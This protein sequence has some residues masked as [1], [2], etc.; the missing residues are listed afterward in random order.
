VIHVDRRRADSAQTLTRP[1]S[2]ATATMLGGPASSSTSL[3]ARSL[4][5]LLALPTA[6]LLMASLVSCGGPRVVPD[7]P[8]GVDLA[9]QW[10]LNRQASEDPRALI[11]KL[12]EKVAKQFRRGLDDD[13]YRD[14]PDSEPGTSTGSGPA[15]RGSS[16]APGGGADARGARSSDQGGP[17]DGG[18]RSRTNPNS[19]LRV[20][21]D[22]ALGSRLIGDGLTIEQSPDRFAITRGDW[23]RS[24]TPGVHS[25]V[26]VADGVADQTSGWQGREYVIDV[27]PQVGPH[28]IERYA[29]SA[30]GQ[31]IEKVTLSESGLPKL[32]FTR[33]YER[34]VAPPR[35]LPTSN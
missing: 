3:P 20:R 14:G 25:V 23:R 22:A 35:D 7:A 17:P 31:L 11:A 21:Y 8:V 34:G 16:D 27:N 19:F 26:S 30:D 2:R 15:G 4:T 33:V 5:R 24:Y 9:G 10:R 6:I 18:W 12:Q 32:E 13:L 28:L 1:A 29:L